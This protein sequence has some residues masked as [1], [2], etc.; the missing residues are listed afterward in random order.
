MTELVLVVHSQIKI[1]TKEELAT[2]VAPPAVHV[3]LLG[4][5]YDVTSGAKHYGPGG[6]Y[7]FFAGKDA[8]RAFGTGEYE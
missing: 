8:T 6:A 5:V 4:S 2:K 1:F 3:A 7:S